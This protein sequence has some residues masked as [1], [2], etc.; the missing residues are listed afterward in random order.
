MNEIYVDMRTQ[1]EWIRKYFNA[2]FVTIDNLLNCIEELDGK[3]DTLEET[4]Q[5]MKQDIQD[6]YKPISHYEEYGISESDFH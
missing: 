1:G 3:I 5:E 2:D 6:N 4:I